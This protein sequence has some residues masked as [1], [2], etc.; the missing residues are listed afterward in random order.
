MVNNQEFFCSYCKKKTLFYMESDFIWYCDE[1]DN[2]LGERIEEF[3]DDII[4]FDEMDCMD[5]FENCEKIIRCPYCKELIAMNE[6]V[7]DNLCPFCMES[8][9]DNRLIEDVFGE[10]GE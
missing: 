4:D 5:D 9:F 7:D 10:E 1:C 6:L 3:T 2:P 8:I